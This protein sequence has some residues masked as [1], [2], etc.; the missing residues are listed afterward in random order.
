MNV[1][2]LDTSTP[3]SAAAVLRADGQAFA[4]DPAPAE[5]AG[6]PTHSAQLLPRAAAALEDAGLSWGDIDVVAVG[7]GPGPFT[8]LRIGVATARALAGAHCLALRPVSSLAALAAGIDAPLA[9]P[10]IDAG[11]GEVFAA[12]YEG[13]TEL[14]PAFAASP[15][16]VAER[17]HQR[18]QAPDGA[19][20]AAGN[21][22]IRW[23][24]ALQA[25]GVPVVP[26]D[27]QAQAPSAV[28]VCRL[29]LAAPDI[30]AEAVLPHYLREPDV[31]AP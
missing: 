23:M 29:A 26:A 6:R 14:W 8:G 20:L 4:R 2:G 12:L 3:A 19:L 22:S 10:L 31:Q 7:V 28:A 21:G 25:G 17:V 1:L 24:D 30:P 18:G 27:Q 16:A 9:L 15:E 13:A 5:V 11:R